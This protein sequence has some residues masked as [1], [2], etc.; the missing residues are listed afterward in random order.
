MVQLHVGHGCVQH[1]VVLAQ[2]IWFDPSPPL[3]LLRLTAWLQ[4]KF[5]MPYCV[6]TGELPAKSSSHASGSGRIAEILSRTVPPTLNQVPQGCPVGIPEL[7]SFQPLHRM[8]CKREQQPHCVLV[9][10]L[11]MQ[12]LRC[13]HCCQ[14]C[15]HPALKNSGYCYMVEG[16]AN[17]TVPAG[18]HSM[19]LA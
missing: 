14:W 12:T 16:P 4:S 1:L 8:G 19:R 3:H 5:T 11:L 17:H 18:S 10:Q 6:L 2:W 7:A 9:T 13:R 15:S